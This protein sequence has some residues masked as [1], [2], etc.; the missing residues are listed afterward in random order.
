MRLPVRVC[1]DPREGLWGW[2]LRA[3]EANRYLNAA[4]VLSMVEYLAPIRPRAEVIANLA[5]AAG[6]TRDYF[7]PLVA[8]R[9]GSGY[10]R[11]G[12]RGTD[13]PQ[14]FLDV[15]SARVCQACLKKAKLIPA[16]WDLV[17]WNACPCHGVKLLSQCPQCGHAVT[18]KRSHLD[19][20]GNKNCSFVFS[21]SPS[22]KASNSELTLPVF[23]A[24]SMSH[25]T[26]M[27]DPDL[28]EP[29]GIRHRVRL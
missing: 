7:E 3:A 12:V 6:V 25:E 21:Q 14:G 11:L 20:C 23:V 5:E 22:I 26:L 4:A 8:P 27:I 2:A 15:S 16:E 19:R 17:F 10:V 18:W 1:P 13:V 29:F 24:K 28:N 9:R